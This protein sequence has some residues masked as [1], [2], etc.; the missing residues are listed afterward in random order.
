MLDWV[1]SVKE[2]HG[3]MEVNALQQIQAINSRGFYDVGNF[4][5]LDN[6]KVNKQDMC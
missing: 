2:T 6:I 1:K 4:E 5:N 3:S